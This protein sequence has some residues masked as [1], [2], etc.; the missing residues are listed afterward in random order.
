MLG[1]HSSLHH[2]VFIFCRASFLHYKPCPFM[3]ESLL[4]H[5]LVQNNKLHLPTSIAFVS[6]CCCR[7]SA[8]EA[9]PSDGDSLNPVTTKYWCPMWGLWLVAETQ[10][11]TASSR[12]A[13][14]WPT[15]KSYKKH[16]NNVL[17]HQKCPG[18]EALGSSAQLTSG[19]VGCDQVMKTPE[20]IGPS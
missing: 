2:V 1:C 4:G 12:S 5:T 3:Y 15:E 6:V 14:Q 20:E 18:E 13:A 19:D 10:S 8:R 11:S 9:T 7:P 16:T 17:H